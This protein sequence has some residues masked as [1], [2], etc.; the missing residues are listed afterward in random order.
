M[1][2]KAKSQHTRK[3]VLER[4]I[5]AVA[6]CASALAL[7]VLL[8]GG[9]F[10]GDWPSWGGQPSRN[11][12]SETE[13]GLPDWYSLGGKGES[14]GV[15]LS[16]T[17]NVKWAGRL[18]DKTF[19]SPVVSQGR[20]FIGT[21]G[22]SAAEAPLLCFDEK[23]GRELGRYVCGLPHTDNF[24]VCSTPT[25][26]GD[27]LYLVTPQ[28]A[29]VC[30]DLKAWLSPSPTAGA[31]DPAQYVVWRYDMAKSLQVMQDHVASCSVLVYDDCVYVC[32]GNGRWKGVGKPYYPLTPSFI[33]LNKHTGALVARDDEQIGEQLWRGQWSSP[34]LATVNGKPQILFATGNGFCYG[35]E[36][37]DPSAKA[38][39]DGWVTTTL[40]GPIVYY[41]N[42]EK[43]DSPAGLSPAEYARKFNLLSSAQTP[44][45]PVEFR[46]SIGQPVTTPLDSVPTAKVPDVPILKKIWSFDCLPP[47]Y[48][49][50]PFYAHQ[51]KGDA[52]KHP[53]DIICT[54]VCY[55]NRVY[56]AIGGDPNHGSKNSLGNLVCIDPTKAGDIT[57]NGKVWNYDKMNASVTTVSI[58]DGLLF[59]IDEA[60]VVH[61][62]DAETGSVYW[63]YALD[64]DRGL[65]NSALLAADGKLFAGK[66]I[67]AVSKTLKVLGTIEGKTNNNCSQPCVANG[68]LFTV[69]GKWLWAV[70]DKGE[71]K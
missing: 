40:R 12:A 61:C 7:L 17:K 63:T 13:K 21:T 22:A 44:A 28:A 20:V 10:A 62:L 45:L 39:P 71:K 37:A 60:S 65:L 30:L 27:R 23:T 67:L 25:I 4:S 8:E 47:E 33:A 2:T 54:P 32:T 68:V 36:P 19:G 14:G 35:F 24:G 11:M 59:I 26:E 43:K 49:N 66:T 56:V 41:I 16:T 15:D 51:I 58:A 48:R 38:A 53:C 3:S 5:G 9:A 57:T 34:S 31:A 42:V 1:A 52:Q 70:C 18:G 64:S 69:H 46:F 55:H 29:V 50:A 6:W